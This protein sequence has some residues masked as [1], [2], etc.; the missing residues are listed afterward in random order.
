[1]IFQDSARDH[2]KR[3]LWRLSESVEQPLPTLPIEIE[4]SRSLNR[5]A[6]ANFFD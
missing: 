1:M 6:L 5:I 3:K 4:L 2:G